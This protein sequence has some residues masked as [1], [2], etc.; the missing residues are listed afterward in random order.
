[1][2]TEQKLSAKLSELP[3]TTKVEVHDESDGC[4]E[5]FLIEI[6]SSS[7]KGLSR[8]NSHRLVNTTIA[9]EREQIHALTIKTSV[10]EE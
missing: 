6:C 2:R 10:P 7:F 3:G 9:E 8:L 5:K 4:G 1:M